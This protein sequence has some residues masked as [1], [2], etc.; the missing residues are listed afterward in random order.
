MQQ[1]G[2]GSYGIT[3]TTP[4]A[5]ETAVTF[6]P[7]Y[8]STVNPIVAIT[9]NATQGATIQVRLPNGTPTDSQFYFIA[10]GPR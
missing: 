10:I 6:T 1:W 2:I 3:Y 8:I 4:F 5:S 9:G 7:A